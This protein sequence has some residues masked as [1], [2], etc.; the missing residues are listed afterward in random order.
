M[1]GK[2][3]EMVVRRDGLGAVMFQIKRA[4]PKQK[5]RGWMTMKEASTRFGPTW[6]VLRP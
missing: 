6:K 1:T 2:P 5:P 3:D 4:Q